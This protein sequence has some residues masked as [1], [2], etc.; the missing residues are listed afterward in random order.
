MKT[1]QVSDKGWMKSSRKA[2]QTMG[3]TPRVSEL[4]EVEWF[5][6]EGPRIFR[7]QPFARRRLAPACVFRLIV[8][9]HAETD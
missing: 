2:K 6:S 9:V 1:E 7:T 8:E 4:T 5:E 3:Q